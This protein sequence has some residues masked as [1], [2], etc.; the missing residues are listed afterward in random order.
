LS[1]V[2]VI[3][4]PATTTA[5]LT[6][7]MVKDVVDAGIF[8]AGAISVICGSNAGEKWRKKRNRGAGLQRTDSGNLQAN[9]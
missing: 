8:P 4:K 5:W 2:P 1:G 9:G 6:Q 3:V 7:R